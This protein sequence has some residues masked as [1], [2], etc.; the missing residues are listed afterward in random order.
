MEVS[1]DDMLTGVQLIDKVVSLT[2]LPH[3]LMQEELGQIIENSGHAPEGLTL[4]QLREAMLAYLE[5]L[6]A[7][8]SEECESGSTEV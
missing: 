6:Y 3:S 7:S 2:Q 4:D 8:C 1:G 5:S